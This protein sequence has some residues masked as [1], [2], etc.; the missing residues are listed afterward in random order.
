[1]LSGKIVGVDQGIVV[2]AVGEH[3]HRGVVDFDSGEE[4]EPR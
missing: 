3:C 4:F 1:M 2:R